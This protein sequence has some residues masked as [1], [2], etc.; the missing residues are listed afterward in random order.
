[1]SGDL[2]SKKTSTSAIWQHFGFRPNDKG[3]PVNTDEAVCKICMKIVIAR[4]GN[5]SNLR[6]HIRINHP[7]TAARMDLDPPNPISTPPA[8]SDAEATATTTYT[9]PT[10]MGAFGKLAKY[11]KHSVRWKTCTDAVTKY[12]AKAMVS[13]HTVEKKSFKEMI[14]ALDAQYQ[15]PGRKYF[16]KTAIPDLYNKVRNEV[17]VLLSGAD[18]YSLTTDMWS[19]VNMTPYMSL[20]VHIITPEWKLESRCLQTTY[21]PESHTADH[22]AVALRD[23]LQDWHLDEE[24]LSA[25]TTDNAANIAAAIRSLHWPW[26]NCFGHNLNLAVTNAVQDQRQ[27]TERTLGL[28]RN[29]VGAFSHS[30]QRKRELHKK[31]LELGLP[32]HSLITV[33]LYQ[34]LIA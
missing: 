19:S 27:K 21:F 6:T 31:Q 34:F 13:F 12:L 16:S 1:M 20:T 18:S 2:V 8:E 28:C 23:A 14:N 5:T 25:I 29:I 30:W 3:E 24:K 15:L 11:K 33:S 26:L 32:E 22:L 10:I 7:L 9:Q 17:Q 4:D